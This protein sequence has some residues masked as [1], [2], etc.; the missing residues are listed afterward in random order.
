[1]PKKI[2]KQLRKSIMKALVNSTE[3]LSATNISE[4]LEADK[5]LPQSMK[6]P[7]R[8]FTFTMK[9]FAREVGMIQSHV[10]ASNGISRH[11][12]PRV[13]IGYALPKSTTLAEAVEAAGVI[14][15][16][17]KE[18]RLI[19]VRMSLTKIAELE[20]KYPG[21]T[22]EEILLMPLETVE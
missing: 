15:K 19:T 14:E 2:P 17:N 1:M 18:S 11:G 4:R 10:M 5:E 9:Q 7:P 22:I 8:Q 6:K 21:L 12:S 13:R 20:E 16:P 3:P